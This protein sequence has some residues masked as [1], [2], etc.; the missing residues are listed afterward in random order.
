MALFAANGNVTDAPAL[1]DRYAASIA[2]NTS[3]AC[4]DGSSTW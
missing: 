2:S 4:N 1:L 3:N